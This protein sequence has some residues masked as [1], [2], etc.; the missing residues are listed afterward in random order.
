MI[1]KHL[2]E[3]IAHVLRLTSDEI[4][5]S[6]QFQSLGFDSLMAMELRNRLETSMG[7][8]LPA[9]LI[10]TYP[11]VASLGMHLAGKIDPSQA[12]TEQTRVVVEQAA[13]EPDE[14]PI[15]SDDL[16]SDEWADLLAKEL[17]SIA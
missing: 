5:G 9:T 3:Q 17:E 11:T 6:T 14:L 8:T 4:H 7:L 13:T 2:R 12:A 1:E 10:W 16:S 15:E